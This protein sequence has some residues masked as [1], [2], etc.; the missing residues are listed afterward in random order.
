[1]TKIA[2]L[3]V[4][5]ALLGAKPARADCDLPENVDLARLSP[6]PPAYAAEVLATSRQVLPDP[7]MV[8]QVLI[9][10][11]VTFSDVGGSQ[12]LL[13]FRNAQGW[14]G[15]SASHGQPGRY[16]APARTFPLGPELSTQLEGL[17]SNAC[18]WRFPPYLPQ[19]IPLKKGRDS[20]CLDG[21]DHVIE[22][23][24][25]RRR[26]IGVQECQLQGRPR[27][28]VALLSRATMP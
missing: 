4:L 8:P 5:T 23:R 16:A 28:I 21:S 3:L 6:A 18:L 10:V 15:A 25:G 11:A 14:K 27:E 12:V 19:T 17:L 26:W 22:I 20:G 2:G 24:S 9:R 7:A 13:A 1:M